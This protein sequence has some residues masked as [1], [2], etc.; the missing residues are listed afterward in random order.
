[1]ADVDQKAVTSYTEGTHKLGKDVVVPEP[2]RCDEGVASSKNAYKNG[3]DCLKN[4]D[5]DVLGETDRLTEIFRFLW[6]QEDK[7]PA[8]LFWY[9]AVEQ[10][11]VRCFQRIWTCIMIMRLLPC[12]FY[13]TC[14]DVYRGRK[15][16][17]A[18]KACTTLCEHFGIPK[19]E[20]GVLTIAF[21]LVQ[22]VLLFD[23]WLYL[24]F[25]IQKTINDAMYD[26]LG[27]KEYDVF[28]SLM[29]L[30]FKGRLFDVAP[31]PC[32]IRDF[33]LTLAHVIG[34][35]ISNIFVM[36]CVVLAVILVSNKMKRDELWMNNMHCKFARLILQPLIGSEMQV[37]FIGDGNGRQKVMNGLKAL[38]ST[39]AE[40]YAMWVSFPYRG[41]G[42]HDNVDGGG[43]HHVLVYYWKI[44][45]I[46]G[47]DTFWY[48]VSLVTISLVCTYIRVFIRCFALDICYKEDK[49]H[50][51]EQ[52]AEELDKVPEL[53][54]AAKS[55][56]EDSDEGNDGDKAVASAPKKKKPKRKREKAQSAEATKP[57]SGSWVSI[58]INY[59]G[60]FER[61]IDWCD[62]PTKSTH[63]VVDWY[64]QL[65]CVV[66]RAGL[67][68]VSAFGPIYCGFVIAT[69][70]VLIKTKAYEWFGDPSIDAMHARFFGNALSP[71]GSPTG[72][73]TPVPPGFRPV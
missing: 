50:I 53:D 17:P 65:V 1:M 5:V 32:R 70:A 21:K 57:S 64:G 72:P 40:V 73:P 46:P 12:V 6:G 2:P 38:G 63:G 54:K 69:I 23:L 43:T 30:G 47:A 35:T 11:D 10:S 44:E 7:S 42:K 28:Y 56:D 14:G 68:F 49:L 51:C 22:P 4:I 48:V 52:P 34:V 67:M 33:L 61:A 26:K 37:A 58:N 31:S 20:D 8:G 41:E 29:Q 18:G 66:L 71:T 24:G 55:S 19:E 36:P 16:P 13:A 15:L 9:E 3:M 60:A 62:C 59:I 45:K 39:V 25:V 27:F